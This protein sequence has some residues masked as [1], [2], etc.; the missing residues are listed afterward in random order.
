MTHNNEFPINDNY[1]SLKIAAEQFYLNLHQDKLR[2]S[3]EDYDRLAAEFEK[4]TGNSV[5]TLVDWPVNLVQDNEPEEPLNKVVVQDNDLNAAIEDYL[6]GNKNYWCNLKYDGGAIKAIYNEAGMLTRIQ[7]T[8]DESTGII[9]TEQFWDIF[10][11]KLDPE[12]GIKCIRGEVVVDAEVYGMT[13]RNKAN[14]LINSTVN[15]EEI[16]EECFV[17]WYKLTFFDGEWSAERQ[18]TVMDFIPIK[19]KIRNRM[20]ITGEKQLV[21]DV[22]FKY[23]AI[24]FTKSTDDSEFPVGPITKFIDDPVNFQAD[25]VVVYH[26]KTIQGFKYYYTSEAVTTVE[27]IIWNK[28]TNGSYSAVLK[29]N[30]IELDGKVINKA[31]SNGVPKM[32]ESHCG[33]GSKVK[34]ILANTTIPKVI[35]VLE[36]SDEFNVPKC[37]C[38]HDLTLIGS[39]MKCSNPDVCVHRLNLWIPEFMQWVV[40]E[41]LFKSYTEFNQVLIEHPE[42]IGYVLHIDRWDPYKK[43][44]CDMQLAKETSNK[45]IESLNDLD[46][47]KFKEY[48]LSIFNLTDLQEYN[49]NVNAGTAFNVLYLLYKKFPT[50]DSMRKSLSN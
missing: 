9:R 7:S 6:D 4:D 46:F 23:A 13:A 20:S 17:R 39:V 31:S 45:L 48:C 37:E 27:D 29:L 12:L 43:G 38:G 44:M 10:P 41:D 18:R 21:N 34:V 42:F 8:P 36:P 16:N 5:K 3:D 33:V 25:G 26:D 1:Q 2:M 15:K 22:V 49:F 28:Q 40:D 19:T 24:F 14:G 30:T 32:M 47:I 35:E 50:F 11:H